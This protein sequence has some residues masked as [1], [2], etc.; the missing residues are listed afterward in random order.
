VVPRSTGTLRRQDESTQEPAHG[1]GRPD[2][3]EQGEVS[4]G[5]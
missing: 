5:R 1:V 4:G 3:R 2:E